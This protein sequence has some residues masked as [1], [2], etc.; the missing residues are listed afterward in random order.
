MYPSFDIFGEGKTETLLTA[1]PS[2]E[3]GNNRDIILYT[4]YSL[5]ENYL[6]RPVNVLI[7]HDGDLNSVSLV[8]SQGGFDSLNGVGSVEELIIIGVPS[9]ATGTA[10]PQG[11]TGCYQ[12]T[13]EMTPTECDP[14]LNN[15]ADTQAY[16]GMQ[17]YLD[18]IYND[19]IPAVSNETGLQMAEISTVG[20]RYA[21]CALFFA[22]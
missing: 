8:A 17:T 22:D 12:R 10:C 2:A 14:A 4:P 11:S 20:F 18:F 1:F 3:L 5:I 6:P 21:G 7:M 13:Y 9:V 15:C 16:G 19:V